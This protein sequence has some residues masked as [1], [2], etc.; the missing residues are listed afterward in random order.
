MLSEVVLIPPAIPDCPH[1]LQIAM[2]EEFEMS[3]GHDEAVKALGQGLGE[4]DD[5]DNVHGRGV[6]ADTTAGKGN[7]SASTGISTKNKGHLVVRPDVQHDSVVIRWTNGHAN[8]SAILEFQVFL[9]KIREYR[10]DEVEKAAGSAS[11]DGHALLGPS[12]KQIAASSS[13]NSSTPSTRRA[14]RSQG[15]TG[16]FVSSR[17]S[18][19]SP[20]RASTSPVRSRSPSRSG[21]NSPPPS[22]PLFLSLSYILH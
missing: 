9:A 13:S 19:R 18:S 7:T 8:G 3:D 1:D 14:S 16:K 4:D 6:V 12:T 10:S 11:G 15:A 5:E 17:S 21:R 2:L 20:S 22:T